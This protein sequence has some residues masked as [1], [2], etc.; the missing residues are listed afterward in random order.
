MNLLELEIKEDIESSL[1]DFWLKLNIDGSEFLDRFDTSINA[2]FFE[3]LVNSLQGNGAYL[4][5][6]CSC[7]IADCGGWDKIDVK[8]V[9]DKVLWK[10]DYANQHF[11]F[12][13]D[14]LYYKGEIERMQ[15]ELN[16]QKTVLEPKYVIEPE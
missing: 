3:E 11:Q 9:E 4:I 13:F 1:N 6:T 16:L 5:F 12:E 8:H 10:F 2:V 7:G 14:Q 15:F